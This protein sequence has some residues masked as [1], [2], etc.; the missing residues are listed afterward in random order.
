ME[1]CGLLGDTILGSRTEGGHS[2]A[3]QTPAEA[4]SEAWHSGQTIK[5]SM[6]RK[7]WAEGQRE[8][9]EGARGRCQSPPHT[10]D[11]PLTIS[12][13]VAGMCPATQKSLASFLS[14]SPARQGVQTGCIWQS[15]LLPVLLQWPPPPLLAEFHSLLPVSFPDLLP[16]ICLILC[17]AQVF[18]RGLLSLALTSTSR[19]NETTALR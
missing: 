10:L 7:G 15:P 13:S 1:Q 3:P 12:H 16:R 18:L 6:A 17:K 14:L 5:Q 4:A 8:G 19:A 9:I 2:I 11:D